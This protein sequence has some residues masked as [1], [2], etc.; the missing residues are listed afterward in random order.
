M[1]KQKIFAALL[2][3]LTGLAANA[4]TTPENSAKLGKELTPFGAIKAGNAAGTI[5]S[6][7]GGLT[8]EKI[9]SSYQGEGQHHPSPFPKDNP[10]FVIDAKNYTQYSEQLSAGVIEMLRKYP[11]TFRLPIYESRRTHSAPKWVEENTFNNATTA[12]LVSDGAGVAN[13]YGGIPFPIA[14]SATEIL[15]NHIL[16]WRGG[17]IVRDSS[18]AAIRADGR[19]SLT[20]SHVEADFLYY[21]KGGSFEKMNNTIFYYLA[22]TTSPPRLAGGATLIHEK[23]DQKKEARQAWLYSAG[24]RRVRRAPNLA[25]DA[26]IDGSGGLRTTDDTDM[27]N[28]SPERYHWDIVG[29]KELYIPYNNYELGSNKHKYKDI[30]T[31]GHVNPELTRWELHR[32]W[33][34]EGNLKEGERHIYSR[35]T[36]YL[37]EDS[38]SIALADQY[39]GRGQLWRVSIAFLKNYYEVPTTWTAL[40]AFHDLQAKQ[41]H[42]QFLDNEEEKTLSFNTSSPASSRFQPSSLRRLGKR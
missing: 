39:D 13:A 16:R 42:V 3:L 1:I 33:V 14:D 32:V 17:Y 11:D 35:R 8:P 5:P 20:T 26:P 7:Q 40:D 21:Q 24:L 18:E 9:P 34:I 4:K 37:D 29:K 22:Q 30:L 10:L 36:F 15:W 31:P 2:V 27:Y 6:W 19:Y 28:G 12:E 23:M 41:Y 38:W 25:F